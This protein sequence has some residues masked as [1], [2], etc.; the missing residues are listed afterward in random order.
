MSGNLQNPVSASDAALSFCSQ[1][2]RNTRDSIHL[3]RRK[4]S[5]PEMTCEPDIE[6]KRINPKI[7][8]EVQCCLPMRGDT[9]FEEQ[10]F[11]SQLI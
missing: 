6:V 9:A 5:L 1:T 8:K 10:F 3:D 7:S 4:N 2:L 11:E